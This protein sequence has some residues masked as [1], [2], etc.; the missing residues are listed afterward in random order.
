LEVQ[1]GRISPTDVF[2]NN[3][4]LHGNNFRE[5]REKMKIYRGVHDQTYGRVKSILEIP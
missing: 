2:R 1:W 3:Q 4:I 5:V